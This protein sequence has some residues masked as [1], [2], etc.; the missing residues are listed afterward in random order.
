MKLI[1]DCLDKQLVD[2]NDSNMGKCDGIVM[3]LE[4]GG[5]PEITHIEIG[6]VTLATRVHRRFGRWVATQVKRWG[7]A[8]HDPFRIPWSKVVA[9]GVT[10]TVGV[11]AEKT[12]ALAWEQ[13]LRRNVIGRIPGA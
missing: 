11:D 9:T 8:S 3:T 4:D 10:L 2:R 5:Q 6:S 13:W 7:A 1:R 12:S